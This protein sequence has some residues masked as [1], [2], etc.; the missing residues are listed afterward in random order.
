MSE[1]YYLYPI[2][3]KRRLKRYPSPFEPKEEDL[4]EVV[5]HLKRRMDVYELEHLVRDMP[6]EDIVKALLLRGYP[7]AYVMREISESRETRTE[8]LI[9]KRPVEKSS[10]H[11]RELR[12]FSGGYGYEPDSS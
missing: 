9:F 5:K 4:K 7:L 3:L 10:R 8:G 12:I 2:E 6:L 1:E 11:I